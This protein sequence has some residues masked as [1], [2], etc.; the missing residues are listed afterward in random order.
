MVPASAATKRYGGVAVAGVGALIAAFGAYAAAMADS[1]PLLAA[2]QFLAGGGWGLVLMSAVSAA[3]AIGHTGR[4]GK[5]TGSL[6]AL[7][8][9]AAVARI[10]VVAA[11]LAKDPAFTPWLTWIPVAAW[12]VGGAI[13]LLLFASHRRALAP[14]AT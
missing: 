2:M 13:L 1:L 6:F 9:A 8:A 14:A 5:L 7:L 3:I 12:G 10:A 4:E 11:E